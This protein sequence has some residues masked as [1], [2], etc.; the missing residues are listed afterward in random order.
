MTLR[1]TSTSDLVSLDPTG[2][3]LIGG[4]RPLWTVPPVLATT[5]AHV[6]A[7]QAT[8]IGTD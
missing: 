4:D 6:A 2:A 8:A 7:A 5:L 3:A 1:Y